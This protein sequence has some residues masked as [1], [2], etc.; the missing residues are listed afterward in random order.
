MSARIENSARANANELGTRFLEEEKICQL[1]LY[2]LIAQIYCNCED[3]SAV[4]IIHRL[5]DNQGQFGP[6][7]ADGLEKQ[8]LG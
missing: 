4:N 3:L 2:S 7:I 1:H 8:H 5:G 6:K